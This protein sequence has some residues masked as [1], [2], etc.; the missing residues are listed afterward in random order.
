MAYKAH[1][2]EIELPI[3][4]CEL[5]ALNR[6]AGPRWRSVQSRSRFWS[7]NEIS[8]RPLLLR[9]IVFTLGL[10]RDRPQGQ[11]ADAADEGRLSFRPLSQAGIVQSQTA[12]TPLDACCIGG[13]LHQKSRQSTL[14][15]C[16]T[17]AVPRS[18]TNQ[19]IRLKSLK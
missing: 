15:V 3:V 7:V 1:W 2:A 13:G 16:C 18:I 17:R 14:F 6:C 5:H 10:S 19:E 9:T 8:V 12:R 11:H 4:R